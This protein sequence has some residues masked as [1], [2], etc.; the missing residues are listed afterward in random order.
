MISALDGEWSVSRYLIPE[1]GT[2]VPLERR[3]GGPQSLFGRNEQEKGLFASAENRTHF[4]YRGA[5]S[6]DS[7]VT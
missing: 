3:L 5:R 6:L 1:E 2:L 7:T 4:P